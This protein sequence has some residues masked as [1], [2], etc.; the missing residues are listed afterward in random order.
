MEPNI[1]TR[2]VNHTVILELLTAKE[3]CEQYPKVLCFCHTLITELRFDKP[4]F[5]AKGG[6]DNSSPLRN[7]KHMAYFFR[8]TQSEFSQLG[9]EDV[10]AE[11]YPSLNRI[12]VKITKH[13][14]KRDFPDELSTLKK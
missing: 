14:S 11:R 9:S 6:N 5:V 1:K 4:N 12:M 13:Q 7:R 8:Q 10:F 3:Y 2:Q